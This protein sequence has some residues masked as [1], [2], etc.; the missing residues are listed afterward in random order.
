MEI[1]LGAVCF[2]LYLTF[3]YGLTFYTFQELGLTTNDRPSQ[4]MGWHQW[5]PHTQLEVIMIADCWLILSLVIKV[6]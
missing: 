2:F 1:V 6:N 3:L 4:S 5:T